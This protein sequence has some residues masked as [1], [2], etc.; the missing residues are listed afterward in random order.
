ME[1]NDTF[2][3]NYYAHTDDS[4]DREAR[5]SERTQQTV[6]TPCHRSPPAD[7]LIM[8]IRPGRGEGQK[9]GDRGHHE[10]EG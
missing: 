9:H 7:G 2:Y 4:V 5:Q 1:F 6:T 3:S 8:Q 10:G